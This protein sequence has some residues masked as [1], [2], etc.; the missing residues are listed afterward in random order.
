MSR[1]FDELRREL[2]DDFPLNHEF[3]KLGEI[4]ESLVKD[5]FGK[6]VVI[7]KGVTEIDNKVERNILK[8]ISE[9]GFYIGIFNE[10]KDAGE[11]GL[12]LFGGKPF[13]IRRIGEDWGIKVQDADE[14]GDG[15]VPG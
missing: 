8:N 7:H 4:R 3:R 12:D 9:G 6:F 14:W 13:L 15:I 11:T 10:F 5:Y 1:Q 2:G